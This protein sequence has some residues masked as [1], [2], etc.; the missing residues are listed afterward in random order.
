MAEQSLRA[1]YASKAW[2]IDL[3]RREL[4]FRGVSVP[5]GSR[6]FEILEVLV[7]SG[8]ELVNKYHLAGRGRRG[9][10]AAF[11]CV[12]HSQGVGR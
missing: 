6:A 10:H 11:S 2:E 1:V 9:K 3:H 5:I 4:R 7:Q 12:R 8:G